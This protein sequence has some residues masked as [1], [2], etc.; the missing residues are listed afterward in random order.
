[1]GERRRRRCVEKM[2]VFEKMGER[3]RRCWC[4]EEMGQVENR[5]VVKTSL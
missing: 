1:M 4:F 3:R 2:E 5:E